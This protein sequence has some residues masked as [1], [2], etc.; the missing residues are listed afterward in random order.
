EIVKAKVESKSIALKAKK[1]SSDE[2]CST[3]SS[4]DEEYS[5]A[6][7]DFKKFFKR[8]G[9]FVRQPR[10]DKK[11]FQRSRDDK[12]GKSDRKCFRCG[13]PNH[14][15][16]EC[17][18][19][20][21]DKN[22]RAFVGGSWSDSGEEDDEKVKNETC[23]VAHA[24]SEIC[25]GVDLEPDEWIK[26]SGCSKHMTG[27]RKLFST[28]KAY[29]GGN[30][31]FGSNLRG[32][33]I[34]KGTISNDSLKI[35]NVEHV[36][37]LRFNL[38]SIGQICDNKCRVTF[39]EHDSEITKDGKVI[40]RGIRKKGLYVMK[41]GNK[42]NDQICLATI[43][44]NST[45][46]HRRLGHA[47]MHLIQLLAS[48]ELVRNLP[49]LK[50]DQH[51]CD[52]CKMG[53]QAHVSHKAKNIVSTTR[54]LELL[55]MDLF[56]PSA[57]RSYGG[58]RYT[59]VIV[60][61][62][63]RYTWTRFLKDK[64]E[65]FDQ[66]KIFSRQI[67]NQLGCSIVSIRTDHGREFDNEV[68]FGEFCNANGITHNFSAPRTPQSNGVVERK[69][70]TLQEMSRT[71]LNEQSL[72]Q[73]FWCNAVDTSTYILNRI[74]IRAILGKTP[75]E[76][77]RGR[78]PTLDYFRV[79][80][81]KCFI[82]NTKDYLTKFD[83]KSYEGVFLGYSQNSKAYII[84]NKHTRKVEESLNVTFDETPPPSKTSPLVD[85]DLD[86]EEAIKV[87]EKKNLEN[88]IVDETLEI[89]EIVNIKESRNHPLENVIGNLNQRT[90]RSQA[91]NQSNFFCFISTIEPKNVNEALGDESWIVAMQEELNQFVANDVWELVPQPRNMTIIGTKWVF[92]NKLDENGIVSRNKARLV[93]QGYN[94]QEGIDYDE[95]YALVARLESIRILLAYA[96]ALDFKLFQMDVKSAFLN[97][98]INEEVYVAQPPGF[99]DFEKPDHVYK[100]KKALYGLKQAPKAWYDRLKA[101]LI[102]HEYKNR[103]VIMPSKSSEDHKNTRYYNP[104]ISREFRSPLKERLRN[105]ESCYIHEGQAV[106]E[107][108]A[109]LRYVRSF[110]FLEFEYLL[111]INDQIYPRFILE[112]YSQYQINYSDE[113]QILIEFLI[114]NQFFSYTLEE[115]AQ[116]LDIPCEGACVFTDKWSLDELAYG[117]PRDGPY[118]TNPPS[119]DD[120]I[121]YIQNDREGQS[122]VLYDRVMNPLT[123]QQER[124]TRKDCGT[125]RGRHSTSSSSAF[126]QPSSSHLND[127]DDDGND[128]GTSRASTPSPTRFVNSLT[129]EVPQVFQNPPNI[130]PDMEPFYTRQT[131]II[132]RQVQ[133]R[134][135]HRGGLRSIGKGL[136][137]LWR[138]MKKK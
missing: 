50:F 56:G 29:N 69:N 76:L 78:K 121:S 137:N 17:P 51:F 48:K 116:I 125:R 83:P 124:K 31:I 96:C 130:D 59:L 89:D 53:K 21:K 64:T 138:N 106:F 14:L 3:S 62:Y 16:G 39:S 94:Q 110:S 11:T 66:F 128:E 61:D 2:E 28:Y 8:R 91:Q 107:D 80:G 19:P 100:L 101:F 24:S 102:K 26:D 117:V 41:L 57:V 105:L 67:Q 82:L 33:I 93:A 72:P 122:Y 88:D 43:D 5:M 98:F 45:L 109:D 103:M 34:G 60:D 136:K 4:E 68:Q 63:S 25:L 95:T 131:K 127:D 84:L 52:A 134:D 115:F 132:N 38:L 12:N 97:G 13:D 30:V 74:L 75:Y 23:L 37:N 77:L 20:P 126:D 49:K 9:R 70:R 18:K 99:I 36:D 27:N 85:D 118:Q 87:T 79:F 55:H 42:P 81:S 129:N 135:E 71:M 6:V 113:G 133:L 22:Q 90:L 119:P 35:D 120:I 86:E 65:A 111:E 114:Q 47:N 92:R 123:A 46:W 7:R 54:C 40:G 108:F 1:E 104:I 32:N 73:K 15:I 112:F 44:E 58:N 10:N